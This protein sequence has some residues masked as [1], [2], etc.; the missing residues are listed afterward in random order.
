M[1]GDGLWSYAA[2]SYA[3]PF[4]CAGP[5]AGKT[6]LAG[7]VGQGFPVCSEGRWSVLRSKLFSS[8]EP[9]IEALETGTLGFCAM[10]PGVQAVLKKRTSTTAT[11]EKF[12]LPGIF[13]LSLMALLQM[14]VL[15]SIIVC[16]Q[17][18]MKLKNRASAK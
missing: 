16:C 2:A 18:E 3:G 7:E 1:A 13:W 8:G 15:I 9:G 11:R 17:A 5:N 6:L 4:P 10:L 14:A 12:H